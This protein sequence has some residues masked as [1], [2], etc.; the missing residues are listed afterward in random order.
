MAVQLPI[1][2]AAHEV[3]S[4][5]DGP[6]SSPP[7][8]PVHSEMGSGRQLAVD[9]ETCWV[10]ASYLELQDIRLKYFFF[11]GHLSLDQNCPRSYHQL[12]I[13]NRFQSPISVLQQL[14]QIIMPPCRVQ[15]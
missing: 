2:D 14:Q 9:I 3:Y 8:P 12:G 10:S 1:G 15:K 4:A 5:R 6:F 11:S 13:F 7:A